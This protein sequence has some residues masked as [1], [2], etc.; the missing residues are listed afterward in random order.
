MEVVNTPETATV[1]SQTDFENLVGRAAIA[2]LRWERKYAVNDPFTVQDILNPK[3]ISDE[4]LESFGESAEGVIARL[5]RSGTQ[6]KKHKM[7]VE[8]EAKAR[9][10]FEFLI[11]ARA[12]RVEEKQLAESAE[13]HAKAEGEMAEKR[14]RLLG[15]RKDAAEKE[16]IDALTPEQLDAEYKAAL[17]AKKGK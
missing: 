8:E 14:L 5:G 13:A 16:R 10:R 7:T 3:I 17:A 4:T 11:A 6:F 9:L 2:D 1:M 15:E 12:K